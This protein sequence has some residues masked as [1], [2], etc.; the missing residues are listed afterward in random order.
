MK[1]SRK[2]FVGLQRPEGLVLFG[3][4]PS[5]TLE[6]IEFEIVLSFQVVLR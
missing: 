5:T 4:G 6:H 3:R 2:H 1:A